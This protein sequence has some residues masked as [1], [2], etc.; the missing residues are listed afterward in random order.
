MTSF[1]AKLPAPFHS[2][3]VV[4]QSDDGAPQKIAIEVNG[5][6]LKIDEELLKGHSIMKVESILHPN[7]GSTDS[8]SV[9]YFEVL[10]TFGES[11][12][13]GKKPCDE[14]RDF[15][16]E[17]DMV[18]FRVDRALTVSRKMWPARILDRCGP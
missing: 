15:T 2:V 3:S 12:K 10:I 7:P 4:L 9:E 11:Y 13:V 1:A 14:L 16:W 18:V 5:K 8:G 17:T 6:S